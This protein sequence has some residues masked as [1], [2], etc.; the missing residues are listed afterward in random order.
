MLVVGTRFDQTTPYQYTAPYAQRWPDARVLTVEGYGHTTI[1]P[2]TCAS[3]AIAAYL[4][5]LEARD[6]AVCRQDVVPFGPATQD[7]G[8][9]GAV[10]RLL[11]VD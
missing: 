8:P 1:V 10:P 11:G 7:L 4:V 9:V 3:A 6:G 5:G 2:S